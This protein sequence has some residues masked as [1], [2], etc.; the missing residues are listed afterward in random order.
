MAIEPVPCDQSA[1]DLISFSREVEGFVPRELTSTSLT[2]SVL[3]KSRKTGLQS[4]ESPS[5]PSETAFHFLPT[6]PL[7]SIHPHIYPHLQMTVLLGNHAPESLTTVWFFSDFKIFLCNWYYS[8]KKK[9][10]QRKT[11]TQ[12]SKQANKPKLMSF[13]QPDLQKD[14]WKYERLS[15][16]FQNAIGNAPLKFH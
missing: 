16:S 8:I 3:K 5:S 10:N 13:S 11:S 12:A 7:S 4:A 15:H 1:A 9:T 14:L 6:F 2:E